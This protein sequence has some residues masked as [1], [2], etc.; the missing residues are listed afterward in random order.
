MT[1]MEGTAALGG[2]APAPAAGCDMPGMGGGAD[3]AAAAEAPAA[4]AAPAAAAAPAGAT[5]GASLLQAAASGLQG[6]D[7]AQQVLAALQSNGATID[8]VDDAQFAAQYGDRTGGIYDPTTNKLALPAKTVND[9][10]QL[11]L[12]LLHEG[13]HWLQDNVQGGAEGLGGAVG[14]ALESAGAIQQPEPGTKAESQHDEAQAYLLEALV[15][16]QLGKQ[17][18]GLGVDSGGR[19][20]NYQQILARVQATPEY[21]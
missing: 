7:I 6:S 5:Q 12:V 14:Q 4:I 21:A 8:V 13:V 3:A 17:D 10:E 16:N 19:A 11:Q 2:G 20:M 18:E 9:P 1:A 15:A